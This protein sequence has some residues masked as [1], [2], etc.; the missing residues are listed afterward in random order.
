MD[1]LLKIKRFY[2]KLKEY[3]LIVDLPDFEKIDHV[4]E[5][6]YHKNYKDLTVYLTDSLDK[7]KYEELEK[8]IGEIKETIKNDKKNR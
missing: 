7:E 8:A 2:D 1:L 5:R 6:C 4:A 3:G